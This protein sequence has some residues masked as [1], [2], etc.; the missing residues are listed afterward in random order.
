[1]KTVKVRACVRG[2]WRVC[3]K[4][5]NE[6]DRLVFEQRIRTQDILKIRGAAG[7]DLQYDPPLPRGCVIRHFVNDA[8]YEIDLETLLNHPEARRE[9]IGLLH[10]ERV[11]LPY[12][13]WRRVNDPQLSLFEVG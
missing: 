9:K 4:L 10:P 3:G 1:M 11:Y 12:R 6:A 2:V 13:F 5:R 8:V 7:V